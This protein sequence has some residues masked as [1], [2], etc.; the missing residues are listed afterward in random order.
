MNFKLLCTLMA[1]G[2]SIAFAQE[3]GSIKGQVSDDTGQ[4]LSGSNVM[5][6]GPALPEGTGAVTDATGNFWIRHLPPGVYTL[7]ISHIGYKPI[8]Q[9][10]IRVPMGGTLEL[11]F[12]LESGP[13]VLEQMVV[14]A[15]RRLEKALDAP[16]SIS[17]VEA[18]EIQDHPAL[19]VADHV[20]DLPAVDFIQTGMIQNNVVARGFN[21]LF[22]S[23][24]DLLTLTDYRIARVASLRLN[25]YQFIPVTNEDIE[26]IEVVLG[27]GSALYGP[28][29]PN[30]VMHLITYSPFTSAGT[31]VKVGI[32]ERSLRKVS[33]RHAGTV[34]E[35][36]GYKISSQY[37]TGTDWKHE[38]PA[39]QQARQA[40]PNLRPR[41]FDIVSKKMEV[42]F[43]IKPTEELTAIGSAGYSCTNDIQ[44]TGVGATQADDW[45]YHFVQARFRYRDWFAQVFRNWSDAGETFVLAS[46][47]DIVDNSSLTVFQIQH[48]AAL[49][50]R[51]RFIYGLDALLTRPNT[52]GTINGQ[53]EDHDDINE[54]GAYLQSETTLAEKLDLVLA[55]RYDDHNRIEDAEISPRAALVFKPRYDQTLRVTY[56][57]AFSTPSANNLYIDMLVMPD[58]FGLGA[59]FAPALGFSPA[60][61]IRLQ[62]TSRKGFDGG[63]TFPR[64]N[65]GPRFR[66]PFA[67]VAGLRPDQYLDLHD[68]VFT[69]VMWG[70]GRG[71]V[72]ATFVP[73][74][75]QISTDLM[76]QQ[77]IAGGME[78]EAAQAT[79]AQQ[80]EALATV[81]P[82]IVPEQL[83]GLQ[84]VMAKL[85]L[86]TAG[87]DP[88][89]EV[90]D[91]PRVQSTITQT[92]EV[93]Y[94]GAIG[95]KLI[96]A[97]DLY[98]TRITDFV[99]P[100]AVETP[101]VFL[102]P[103]RLSA[104]LDPTFTQALQDPD[105]A[106]LAGA[107]ASLDAL[108]LE[109]IVAGN[110]NGTPVD[111]LT[112][113][114]T[115]GASSIP[116]GTVS[117][118]QSYDP[119]TILMAYRNF[120]KVT[121]HGL[122]LSMAYYPNKTWRLTGNYS[123]VNENFFENLEGIADVPLN[124]PK[125]KLKVG[126]T[127]K[128]PALDLQLGGRLR[129]NSSFPASFGVYVGDVEAYTVLD[130]NL[131]YKLPV[132]QELSLKVDI[133]NGL[134]DKYR[135]FVGAP[136]VGRL[137][138][139]ELGLDF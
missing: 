44:L 100:F 5:V 1:L 13:I 23:S 21:S 66:S 113:I 79:A 52:D 82:S 46:G 27:P 65:S 61:D 76:A 87:F 48:A 123:Y 91:V 111:E 32:G 24:G 11:H 131:V 101:N 74:F 7:T 3:S 110:N 112:Q 17:V 63:F 106:S 22:S 130:L 4:A 75:Q 34:G 94:K 102:D 99:A 49:G 129:Y 121:L 114:F 109:G 105:H 90:R 85:N 56:N 98:R 135:G 88:V 92:Y 116:F 69:N 107:L 127:C 125:H 122:D 2:T 47:D 59:N 30:G 138:F 60:I 54:W 10:D 126:T 64:S 108:Q 43:D 118:E 120:G 77:L 58:P 96:L 139:A 117:P 84:N 16:A 18:G 80:A 103:T 55:L 132:R 97:A 12:I 86:E 37:Y 15:S 89:T 19:T 42:R 104:A 35:R 70:I 29:S 78:A 33:L 115:T 53:N 9:K 128:I 95:S 26:R 6:K 67:P 68:P 14:S 134:N 136:K 62:G 137:V 20:K 38:D 93:G 45:A 40:N 39:E 71:V 51:Q 25:A 36:F 8:T 73:A 72:L 124:A 57:R 119:V 31:N 41:D 50:E 83:A 81:F 133:R 28:N